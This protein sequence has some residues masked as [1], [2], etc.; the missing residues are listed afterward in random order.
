MIRLVAVPGVAE[1][2]DED[3]A[4]LGIRSAEWRGHVG[5]V[6]VALCIPH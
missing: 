2:F 3:T 5:L 1:V 4:D 6:A